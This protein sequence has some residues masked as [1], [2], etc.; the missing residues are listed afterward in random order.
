MKKRSPGGFCRALLLAGFFLSAG[1]GAAEWQPVTPEDLQMTS[2]PKAPG[3]AAVFLYRQVDRDDTDSVEFEYE[4]IKILRDEGRKYAD[5]EITYNKGSERIESIDARTIR[6]DGTVVKFDGTVY[7]K[8]IVSGRGVKM[9]AKTFTLPAAGVGSIIEYRYRRI[10]DSRYVFDSHWIISQELFT[11]MGSFTLIPSPYFDLRWTWPR[12]LPEG[13]QS[14]SKQRGKIRL[15]T[16]DVPAFV[17]EEYMPPENELKYRVDFVYGDEAAPQKDADEFWRKYAKRTNHDFDKFMDRK[18][19]METAAAAIVSSGDDPESRM[20]K[21]YTYVQRIRNLTYEHAQ[22]EEEK[23]RNR[24]SEPHNVE[25]VLSRG[26]GTAAQINFLYVALAR[27]AGLHASIALVPTRD[28]YFFEKRA[29]NPRQFNSNIVVVTLDGKELFL[30]PGVPFTP[31]GTLPWY[32]TAVQI[33]RLDADGGQWS[34]TLLTAPSDARIERTAKLQ[35]EANGTLK[36][37]VSIR[38]TGVQGAWRRL[39]ERDEDEAERKTFLEPQLRNSVPVGVDV[40]LTNTPDWAA[41]DEPLYAEFDFEAPG[42]ATMAGQRRLVRLGLFGAQDDRS[43]EHQMRSQ[44]I[45]FQFPYQYADD[46]SIELPSGL[47]VDSMPK[48]ESIENKVFAYHATLD[49][50][51]SVLRIKRELSMRMLLVD[52]KYYDQVRKYFQTVRVGDEAQVVIAA[53]ARAVAIRAGDGK[54]AK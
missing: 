14:P 43:F 34:Q 37:K 9:M 45:Y 49:G 42:W 38:Y 53:P 26:A 28:Q 1:C 3:A 13:T 39:E 11:R 16:R 33:L 19:A 6:P 48:P 35:M 29:M 8:P 10:L 54:D 12:G 51:G 44:P 47:Q 22:T 52:S 20:R 24:D 36:G 25:E 50:T 30:D 46:I 17:T 5:V 7:E 2:E 15:E 40:K 41:W 27:A 32:E 23:K 4:R 18:K 21:I 31:Y